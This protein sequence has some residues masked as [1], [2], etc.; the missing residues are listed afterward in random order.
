MKKKTIKIPKGYLK[1]FDFNIKNFDEL[2][3]I[4][5]CLCDQ[6]NI[7]LKELNGLTL[8][9]YKEH[10]IKTLISYKPCK[11]KDSKN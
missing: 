6:C 7:S 11:T 3:S 4:K 1:A 5:Y 10:E 2:E 9:E 8:N